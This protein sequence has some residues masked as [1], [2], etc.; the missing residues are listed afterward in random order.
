MSISWNIND[1]WKYSALPKKQS[2]T[3]LT[4]NWEEFLE[5]DLKVC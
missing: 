5:S 3:F 1:T 2:I 4:G